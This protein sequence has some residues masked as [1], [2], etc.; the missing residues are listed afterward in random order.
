MAFLRE[1]GHLTV[2]AVAHWR[3]HV[4]KTFGAALLVASGLAITAGQALALQTVVTQVDKNTDGSVTYHF[5]VKLDQGETLT[6]GE[7]KA[8][9]IS[10]VWLKGRRNL[11]QAGSSRPRSSAEPRH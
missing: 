9:A 5:A 11:Q 7:S 8:A 10:A 2:C 3:D 4:L 1:Q 6:P